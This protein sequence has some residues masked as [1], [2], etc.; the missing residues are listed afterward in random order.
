M[1]VPVAFE[2]VLRRAELPAP[3]AGAGVFGRPKILATQK[4]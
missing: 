4:P 3:A 2:W 1:V